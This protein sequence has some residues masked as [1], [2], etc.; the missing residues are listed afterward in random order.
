MAP[1]ETE[2]AVT[3]R[4]GRS[5][6]GRGASAAHPYSADASHVQEAGGHGTG[7]SDPDHYTV[8]GVEQSAPGEQIERVYRRQVG[9]IHPDKFA[10]DSM[11]RGQ[12]QEKLKQLNAAIADLRDPAR[13][14]RYDAKLLVDTR[15]PLA[16]RLQGSTPRY[17][18]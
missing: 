4:V 18:V 12:A 2:T 6:T 7:S 13:R 10:H 9:L 8:L 15:T 17:L 14:A 16:R 5:S 11:L 1:Y 3:Y